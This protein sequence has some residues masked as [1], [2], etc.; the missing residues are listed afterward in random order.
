MNRSLLVVAAAGVI[1]ILGV[2]ALFVAGGREPGA[3]AQ[4]PLPAGSADSLQ[5]ELDRAQRDLT[6]ARFRV[7]ELERASRPDWI[8]TTDVLLLRE[9]GLA[10]PVDSLKADLERHTDLIP[11]PGEL[12][13]RMFFTD[14]RILDGR[15][16]YA[17][18]EDGHVGGRMLLEYRVRDGRVRWTRI[19]AHRDAGGLP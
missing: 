19:A 8:D 15:W 11:Y 18:F 9:R 1:M 12:G 5:H 10:S 7:E 2:I 17:E 13:G 14:I 4:H 16:A 6:R 3:P